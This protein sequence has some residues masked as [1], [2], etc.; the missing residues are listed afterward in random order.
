MLV[1]MGA[2]SHLGIDL[3]EYDSR[4]RTFIPSYEVM[5]DIVADVVAAATLRARPAIVELG[6]GTG[7]LAARC[8]EV[9]PT[10]RIVGVDEERGML[11]AARARLA[12][13]LH[14][15]LE[16]SF[17]SIDLP[18]AD[19]IVAC[20]ALHH[21]PPGPRRRRLFRKLRRALRPG[22][23]FV[24]ADCF[25]ASNARLAAVDRAAWTAHVGASYTPLEVRAFF[26]R[27]AHEDH[28]VPLADEVAALGRAG[29]RTDISMRRGAFAVIA[30][31]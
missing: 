28:Y 11:A 15:S 24:N 8:L 18:R 23:I 4:I 19:A 31:S 30:A 7:A 9:R 21:V 20:L 12:G 13:R 5:H 27:W 2:Q 10:A 29:F 3:A 1:G 26:R 17:E 6:I 22:G 25:P 14:A 16:G